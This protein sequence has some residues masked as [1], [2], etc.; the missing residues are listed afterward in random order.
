MSYVNPAICAK[1]DSMLPEPGAHLQMDVKLGDH[2]GS[3]GLPGSALLQRE[4]ALPLDLIPYQKKIF[5]KFLFSSAFCS[6]LCQYN[7]RQR[8]DKPLNDMGCSSVDRVFDYESKG[9]GF[10]SLQLQA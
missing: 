8:A 7:R 2:V 4:R 9:R 10:E 3:D 5:E 1:F 6:N